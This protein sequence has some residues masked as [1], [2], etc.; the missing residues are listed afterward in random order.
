MIDPLLAASVL[1]DV[2]PGQD[3]FQP[4]WLY[5]VLCLAV[6][7]VLGALAALLTTWIGKLVGRRRAGGGDA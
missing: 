7:A 2:R 3:G 5:V 1:R 6:P 4:S